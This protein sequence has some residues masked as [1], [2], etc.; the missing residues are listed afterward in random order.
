MHDRA[1]PPFWNAANV[2]TLS[3]LALAPLI[4]GLIAYGAYLA[5]VGVFAVA[6][7]TDWFDGQIARRLGINSAV[8]RQ[9]DPLV[10]KVLVAGCYVYLLAIGPQ[11]GLAPWMVTAILAR[12]L[13]VQ[14]IRGLIEGRGEPFGAKMAGKLKATAQFLAIIAILLVLAGFSSRAWVVARD[15]LIWASVV[16]TVVSGVQY[17]ALAWPQIAPKPG[18]PPA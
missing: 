8:G 17:L 18:R 11:T 15:A 4:F 1:E 16:L 6:A 10:D 5:A 7:L 3:R 12:E 13:I 14:A 2:L 9:L